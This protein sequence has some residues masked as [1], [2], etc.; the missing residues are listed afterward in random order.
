MMPISALLMFVQGGCLARR[1]DGLG[2]LSAGSQYIF[3]V[4]RLVVWLFVV[5]VIQ[6]S[7]ADVD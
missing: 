6:T 5:V 4:V 3:Y 2:R 1:L 7:C